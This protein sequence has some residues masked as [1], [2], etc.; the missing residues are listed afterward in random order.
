MKNE[1]ERFI[2]LWLSF[3]SLFGAWEIH[4]NPSSAFRFLRLSPPGDR[5][6]DVLGFVPAGGGCLK[7]LDTSEAVEFRCSL[8]SVY[9]INY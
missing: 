4:G 6:R 7:L 1:R 3:Y 9:V 8:F 2:L 5:W